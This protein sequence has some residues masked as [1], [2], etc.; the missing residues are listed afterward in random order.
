MKALTTI[1]RF[2]DRIVRL[3]GEYSVWLALALV[4]VILFDV[5][6][7]RFLVLGST[8]LQELEWHIHTVLFMFCVGFA[9]LKDGHVRIDLLREKLSLRTR[10]WIELIGC[11]LFAVPYCA[12]LFWLSIDFAVTAY[13]GNEVSSAGTGLPHRWIIK[14]CLTVGFLLLMLSTLCVALRN[15]LGLF[16]DDAIQAMVTEM[17]VKDTLH[18]DA[19][20]ADPAVEALAADH[21][22]AVPPNGGADKG[23]R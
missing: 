22:A 6:T 9:Y 1:T 16:G 17:E 19:A 21:D 4:L 13:T 15:F 12:V 3:A 2:L 14:A 11:L 18:D 5:I 23:G 20:F 7:R 8:K 10:R